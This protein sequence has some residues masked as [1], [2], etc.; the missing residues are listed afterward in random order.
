MHHS[1]GVL[2]FVIVAPPEC[3]VCSHDCEI[4]SSGIKCTCPEGMKLGSNGRTC[5]SKLQR[6]FIH[7]CMV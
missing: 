6:Q 2:L 1:F 4:T 5:I 7:T 3:K